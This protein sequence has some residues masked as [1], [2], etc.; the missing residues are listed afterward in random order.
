MSFR[1]T[2][3]SFKCSAEGEALF[4]VEG[5]GTLEDTTISYEMAANSKRDWR[6]L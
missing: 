4:Y 5:G 3:K 6:N 1:T 2:E